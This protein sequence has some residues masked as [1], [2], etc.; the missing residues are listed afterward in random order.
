MVDNWRTNQAREKS[1]D[2]RM[3]LQMQ[4]QEKPTVRELN[5][6]LYQVFPDGRATLIPTTG[7]K[8][9]DNSLRDD[10]NKSV[11]PMRGLMSLAEDFKDDYAGYKVGA[12]GD[13]VNALGRNLPSSVVGSD[14]GKQAQWWQSYQEFANLKR[15]ALFGSALTAT[16]KTE[17]DKAMINPG[18]DPGMIRENLRK[19]TAIAKSA[20]ARIAGSAKEGGINPKALEALMGMTFD[21]VGSPMT[22]PPAAVQGAQQ[23]GAHPYEGRTATGPNGQK[24]M[25][26]GG[27]WVPVQ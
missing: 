12:V 21:E 10:L 3:Q 27:Q 7:G 15:N 9:V 11:T 2:A 4:A 14:T 25:M 8:P 1:A 6:Q 17:F 18:M 26:R 19:Q 20:V 5:G 13:V 24:I 16:E 23:G 22:P